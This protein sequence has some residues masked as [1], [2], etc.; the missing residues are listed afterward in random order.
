MCSTNTIDKPAETL[1][2][3][4]AALPVGEAKRCSSGR[5]GRGVS[6]KG[7]PERGKPKVAPACQGSQT[8]KIL[9]I[10]LKP[11]ARYGV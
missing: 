6:W 9:R 11:R 1:A 4:A 7:E 5:M 10:K 8:L 2:K 3:L